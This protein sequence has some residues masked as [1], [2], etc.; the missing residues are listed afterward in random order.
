MVE[1]PLKGVKV[2]QCEWCLGVY[3]DAGELA[4]AAS[5][6]VPP[7]FPGD[8]SERTCPV[9]NTPF[10]LGLMGPVAVD[11]CDKCVGIYLD[12]GE[13]KTLRKGRTPIRTKPREM[14]SDDDDVGPNMAG[15]AAA[16]LVLGLIGGLG[17]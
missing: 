3:F 6:A 9:C 4:E 12:G 14:I 1:K 7:L 16:L 10:R 17:D 2:D 15:G 13:F 5:C 8:P 11:V